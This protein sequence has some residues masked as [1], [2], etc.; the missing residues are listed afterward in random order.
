[1]DDRDPTN[2]TQEQGATLPDPVNPPA[3]LDRSRPAAWGASDEFEGVAVERSTDHFKDGA[4]R[5]IA[6]Y[7]PGSTAFDDRHGP[8]WQYFPNG[9]MKSMQFW[10][11]GV[12]Q[13]AFRAWYPSGLLHWD[14]TFLDGERD[15]FYHQYH[16]GGAIQY[17][18]KYK[19][20]VPQGEWRE[21]LAGGA[22]SKLE[23]FEGGQLHGRRQT[24]VSA[25]GEDP[26]DLDAQ[27]KIY[28]VL[29]ETYEMGILHGPM[30]RYHVG[31]SLVQS[32]GSNAR[33]A[34]TG[35]WEIFFENGQLLSSCSYQEG[36]KHGLETQFMSDGQKVS[37]V[38]YELGVAQGL[39]ESW[40]PDGVLQSRGTLVQGKR[41]G[42][43]LYQ[44]PDGTNNQVWSGTYLDDERISEEPAPS[45][46]G[47]D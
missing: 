45:D 40:Y 14:G 10:R 5:R 42:P 6:Y 28:P 4:V 34:R 13:G 46:T 33:G 39:S 17:E 20:G 1:M 9:T 19:A 30:V 3:A 8:E 37:A 38:E 36:R 43:W 15:G 12:L 35:V 32:R 16:K 29:D 41:Q 7:L 31:S 44:R 25:Q 11:K 18:Y 24:W 2:G 21:F 27:A 26:R 22:L 47:S 23:T